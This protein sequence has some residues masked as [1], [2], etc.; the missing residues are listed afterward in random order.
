MGIFQPLKDLYTKYERWV[1]IASFILGFCFDMAVLHRVDELAVLIQQAAYIIIAGILITV[2]LQEHLREIHPPKGL[3]WFWK[4]REFLLH[5]MLGTLLNSYT[6][7][8]FKSASS[9]TSLAYILGLVAL[10]IVNE[11][12]R[13]GNDQSKVHMAFLSLCLVSYLICLVPIILGFMGTLTFVIAVAISVLCLI[14][15]AKMVKPLFTAQ[16]ELIHTHVVF[17][18]AAVHVVFVLLYFFHVIPP[19]PLSISYIGIYHQ[20][21]KENG[22]YKLTYHRSKWRFW[23]H[24]DQTYLARPGD[25]INCFAQIFAP[26]RFQE[27]LQVR[28]LFKD[29]RQGW[30]SADAIPIPILGGREEGYRVHTKKA[31]YQ[32][33]DWRV[34]IETRENHEIGRINFTVE[35]DPSSEPREE[36]FD[37]R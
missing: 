14:G 9:F 29:P 19:V 5:F 35:A 25:T 15:Y 7:F 13:F 33:G 10:L 6:I 12:K 34:Q 16:P 8:Y 3:G 21:E 24:G 4:Y 26:S 20:V 31:N 17:P 30:L 18:F 32:P 23:E 36:K 11:F 37:L 22:E 1:P 27:Q 2:E 28:W